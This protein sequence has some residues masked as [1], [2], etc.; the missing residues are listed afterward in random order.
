MQT[1]IGVLGAKRAGKD[2]FAAALMGQHKNI[3]R[4]GFADALYKEVSECFD[5]PVSFFRDDARKDKPQ[6]ELDLR[7]SRSTRFAD[8]CAELLNSRPEIREK[9]GLSVNALS[10]RV[11][12]QWYGTDFRRHLFDDLYWINIVR[13]AIIASPEKNF[14]ITDVRFLNEANLLT[15]QFNALTVRVLREK[16]DKAMAA[17]REAGD[18]AALHPSETELL[19]YQTHYIANNIEG[20]MT[21]LS[22][23]ASRF[24]THFLTL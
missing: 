13:D 21:S 5:L 11:I 23:A 8:L 6:V 15:T 3:V 12:L 1:V 24:A 10:P 9:F 22:T 20:D 14:I 19:N 7:F 2:T 18:P 4:L 16:I 17:L